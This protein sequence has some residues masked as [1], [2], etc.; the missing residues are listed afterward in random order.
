MGK[1]RT[2]E[3]ISHSLLL[4]FDMGTCPLHMILGGNYESS[5]EHIFY[6]HNELYLVAMK[7]EKHCRVDNATTRD[8][9]VVIH[10]FICAD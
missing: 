5:R 3:K 9:N 4:Y 10:F 8:A 1:T 6:K 7:V 2:E